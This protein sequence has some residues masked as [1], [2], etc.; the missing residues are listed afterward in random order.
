MTDNDSQIIQC[1]S[2][3]VSITVEKLGEHVSSNP[4]TKKEAIEEQL[5]LWGEV[6]DKEYLIMN[7]VFCPSCASVSHLG[8]WLG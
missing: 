4:G 3:K 7:V 6:Y 8:D 5:Q 1:P 2:C